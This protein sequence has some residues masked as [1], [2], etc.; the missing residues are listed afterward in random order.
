MFSIS[1]AGIDLIK[2]FEGCRLTAYQDSVGVWTVGWG[3][4]G[5]DVTPYMHVSEEEAEQLL[6]N[7]L[8]RFEKCVNDLVKVDINQNEFD[9]LVSFS[10]NLG[11][12]ALGSSTL[13]K[14]LNGGSPRIEV[15][16]E[17]LRWV[18]AGGETLPGLVRRRE[19]ERKLFLETVSAL[20]VGWYIVAK[21][22]T[23]LKK[24]PLQSSELSAE[25]K[26]FV[27][28]G[29]TWVWTEIVMTKDEP[30][31]KVELVQQPGIDWFIYS[32]HW[33]II[34]EK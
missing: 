30:H 12:G 13:L 7:D 20:P 5:S 33:D 2:Q 23:Y 1:T 22:D 11:C 31:S 25:E 16:D 18:K 8:V 28:K 19:A 10:F 17:F 6:K 26:L 3:H 21:Q 34:R 24:K 27:T 4:T 9:A 15:A 14:K 29:S 32:P